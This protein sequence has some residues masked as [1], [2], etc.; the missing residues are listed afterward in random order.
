MATLETV[1]ITQTMRNAAA[2]KPNT[3]GR[4]K[5]TDTDIQIAEWYASDQPTLGVRVNSSQYGSLQTAI[6]RLNDGDA[7]KP[8][9]SQYVAQLAALGL[10]ENSL[11]AH[12]GGEGFRVIEIVR[13]DG[14][15]RE[16]AE[17]DN[18]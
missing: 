12:S 16:S 4:S 11:G 1:E 17:S 8:R 14:S 6:M 5:G 10:T 3:R 7:D 15:P 9:K 13:H 2:D 18:N